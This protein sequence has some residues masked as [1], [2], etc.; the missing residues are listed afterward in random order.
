MSGVGSNSCGPKLDKAAR[1]PLCGTGSILLRFM[2]DE[3]QHVKA[4][5]RDPE[6]KK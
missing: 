2:K 5:S 3:K 1:P 4:D 6:T